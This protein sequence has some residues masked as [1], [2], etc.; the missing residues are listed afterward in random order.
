[1]SQSWGPKN[2]DVTKYTINGI[3]QSSFLDIGQKHVHFED[4]YVL[5]NTKQSTSVP[6]QQLRQY[7]NFSGLGAKIG[8]QITMDV[9]T[10]IKEYFKDNKAEDAFNLFPNPAQNEC[11][12]AFKQAIN[13]KVYIE[14]YNQQGQ[15][16]SIQEQNNILPYSILTLRT[17]NLANGI[18]LVKVQ[19][20]ET[21]NTRKLIIE[22]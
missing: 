22:K 5:D 18:Y 16:M 8:I 2:G 19:S 13:G 11:S 14:V 17:N 4:N 10:G 21:S 1:M 7:Y 6:S 20:G 3:D 12:L 9:I 15:L